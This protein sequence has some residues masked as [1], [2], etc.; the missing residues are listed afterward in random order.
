MATKLYLNN[1]ITVEPKLLQL[2]HGSGI[3]IS[4]NTATVA[5]PTAGVQL[6]DVNNNPMSFLSNPLNG[7]TISGTITFNLWGSES[8]M[9]A[10]VG[11]DAL[12]ER[13]D[14]SGNV[15]S[16]IAR[17]EFG[18]EL[19]VTTR[20]VNNWTAAPTSTTLNQGDTIRVTV[21]GNDV[22]T[23]ASGFSFNLGFSGTTDA[24]DG[25]SYV[26]FT[27][28]ITEG[29]GETITLDKWNQPTNQPYPH[30]TQVIPYQCQ[31]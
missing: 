25:D 26:Q 30:R 10:N 15:I 23:M 22:G 21:F 14:G 18:S 16:T 19:A 5:G 7:V 4:A 20:A 8:N 27:E 29:S 13:C 11:F 3:A 31:A 1:I 2:T 12:V 28:A 9:S 17:S 24:V 6:N